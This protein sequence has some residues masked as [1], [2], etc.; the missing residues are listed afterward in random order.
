MFFPNHYCLHHFSYLL[1][2]FG[3]ICTGELYQ[4][5]SFGLSDSY[6]GVAATQVIRIINIITHTRTS[7]VLQQFSLFTTFFFLSFFL[8]GTFPGS[9]NGVVVDV[10]WI[11]QVDKWNYYT[12]AGLKIRETK[13][14]DEFLSFFPRTFSSYYLISEFKACRSLFG[15]KKPMAAKKLSYE[16]LG[17]GEGEGEGGGGGGGGL[18]PF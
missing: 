15:A 6:Q 8:R 1:K 5:A 16:L 10:H 13:T 7:L 14:I 18:L 12:P 2:G 9:R 3:N 17:K 4:Q 11:L